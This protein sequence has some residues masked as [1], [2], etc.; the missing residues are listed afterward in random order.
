MIYPL[1]TVFTQCHSNVLD[2]LDGVDV[3]YT[4]ILDAVDRIDHCSSVLMNLFVS[5]IK[6][7]TYYVAFNGYKSQRH[8][9]SSGVAQGS[10]LGPSLFLI[11]INDISYILKIRFSFPY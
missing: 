2:S 1:I 5:Y 10:N 3:V 4:D 6:D 11:F 7:R 9:A 8:T